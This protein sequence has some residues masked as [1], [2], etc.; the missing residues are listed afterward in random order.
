M[1]K[2]I[3]TLRLIDCRRILNVVDDDPASRAEVFSYARMLIHERWPSKLEYA[4][5]GNESEIGSHGPLERAEKRVVNKRLKEELRMELLY[6]SY[7]D[8][9]KAIVDE[10]HA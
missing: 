8:G 1:L 2:F 3:L 6:P 10:M 7:K 4:E 9:L 5:N